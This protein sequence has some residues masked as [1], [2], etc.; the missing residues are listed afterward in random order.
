MI[1]ASGAILAGVNASAQGSPAQE[2][3]QNESEHEDD[4]HER[5]DENETVKTITGTLENPSGEDYQLNG[6]AIDIGPPRYVNN[7]QAPVDFDGD[8][9]IETIRAEF[10]GLVG[11]NVTVT[12]ETDGREGD[13]RSV[14]GDQY[15]ED[16]PPPWAGP[17]DHADSD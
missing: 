11:E 2:E 14:T 9:T 8:G 13:V 17:P 10:D 4:E 5:G 6:L 3:P 1:L 15:R 7:A 12:V 16:G